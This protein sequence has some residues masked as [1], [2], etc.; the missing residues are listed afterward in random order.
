MTDDGS[1]I[2]NQRAEGGSGCKE[3]VG[4][5]VPDGGSGSEERAAVLGSRCGGRAG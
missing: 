2:N 4:S 5:E 1:G 3:F